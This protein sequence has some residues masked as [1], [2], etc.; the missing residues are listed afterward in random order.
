MAK[1][2]LKVGTADETK[3]AANNTIKSNEEGIQKLKPFGG[4]MSMKKD[5]KD[6]DMKDMDMKDMDMKDAKKDKSA[7][8]HSQHQ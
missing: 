1:D 8:D 7:T 3:K 5:M 2:Y 4:N 6:M